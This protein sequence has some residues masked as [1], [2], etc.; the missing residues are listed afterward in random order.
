M[1]QA[2]IAAG[3]IVMVVTLLMLA[4]TVQAAIQVGEV[5]RIKASAEAFSE[6]RLSQLVM[7]SPVHMNDVITT[8]GQARLEITFLDGT[9][10]ALGEHARLQID[11]FVYQ[12]ASTGSG[13]DLAIN[14]A[15]RFVT[16]Q[17]GKL[18]QDGTRVRTPVAIIGVRGTD[19][20]AGP[21]DGQYGVVL[22]DGA[23]AVTNPQGEAVL[24]RP[25]LGTNIAGPGE[26][27]G[28]VGV[29]PQDKVARALA[30]VA[31]Q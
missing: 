13:I 25:G 31:F 7:A 23:V 24:D 11:T 16:G 5:T 14:G 12:P 6:G 8:G 30:A 1:R 10:I 26:P 22:F 2:R 18:V 15:F 9:R 29:W 27:P 3:L 28:P 21:I 20:I 4:G 19:F 17:I